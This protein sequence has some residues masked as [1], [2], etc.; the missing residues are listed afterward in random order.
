MNEMK[1]INKI[2]IWIDQQ[3]NND[4]NQQ[5]LNIIKNKF[6]YFIDIYL[7]EDLEEGINAIKQI[8]FI[9]IKL[10]ISGRFYPQF[11]QIYKDNLESF[12]IILE[13]IIF[14]S[15]KNDYLF[16]NQDNPE[17]MLNDNFYNIG[18]VVDN[19]I[20]LMDTL[21]PEFY[22]IT[23]NISEESKKVFN[24]EE[25]NESNFG[26]ESLE[27]KENSIFP[28]FYKNSLNKSSHIS[29]KTF[30]NFFINQY[31]YDNEVKE[32]IKPLL[33]IS[34]IPI[35]ILYKYFLRIYLLKSNEINQQL[36]SKNCYKFTSFLQVMYEAL[37][38][39]LIKPFKSQN[40]YHASYINKIQFENNLFINTLI[41]I[42][43]FLLFNKVKS[44]EIKKFK[45]DKKTNYYNILYEIEKPET[46]EEEQ[47][48]YNVDINE[49]SINK[50]NGILVFPFSSFI[51]SKIG[52]V[53]IEYGHNYWLVKLKYVGELKKEILNKYNEKNIL[54]LIE[55]DSQFFKEL[56]K[57]NSNIISRSKI[58]PLINDNLIIIN[59]KMINSKIIIKNKEIY[60]I[61]TW[62]KSFSNIKFNLLYRLT[63]DG[64]SFST[65]H[66]K[67][68]NIK[69]N[70]IVIE[71]IKG[72]KFG[73]FCP[74]EWKSC[75]IQTKYCEN[76]FLFELNTFNK[77]EKEG[78]CKLSLTKDLGPILSSD[79]CFRNNNMSEFYCYG[80]GGFLT[81]KKLLTNEEEAK[82]IVKEVE[83][84]QIE[85]N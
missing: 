33:K 73:A 14:T 40:I 18:G 84:F 70:L 67:C 80:N 46:I 35:P 62:L 75:A 41:F 37:S 10:M 78:K 34:N 48:C 43:P 79:F 30:L 20:D 57:Y 85:N 29:N 13:V 81:N 22:E 39:R 47:L 82:I 65:F 4:E 1:I 83:I 60:Y 50:T 17:L 28:I 31:S 6:T 12:N 3:V 58:Y 49:Y 24:Y 52:T 71:S 64:N 23:N 53:N 42:K 16:Q 77:F 68:D 44:D 2:L 69:N 26:F 7:Y 61:K 72:R 76:V 15:N 54:D 25:E 38:L 74:G 9:P 66:N 45:S 27:L 55:K 63:S 36:K 11:I 59:N 19:E 21:E 5:F 32:L 8:K 56:Y 51:I